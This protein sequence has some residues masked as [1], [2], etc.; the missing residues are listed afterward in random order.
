MLYVFF[1]SQSDESLVLYHFQYHGWK[2][3]GL[4]RAESLVYLQQQVHKVEHGEHRG[5]IIVHCRYRSNIELSLLVTDSHQSVS[6]RSVRWAAWLKTTLLRSWACH[7]I[8]T[9]HE[10]GKIEEPAPS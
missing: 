1:H 6:P 8:L 4:T 3:D 7:A 5:P 9:P 2:E 10:R